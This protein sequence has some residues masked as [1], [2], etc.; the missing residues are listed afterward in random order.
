MTKRLI[1]AL[2]A[3]IMAAGAFA[4]TGC[5]GAGSG[6]TNTTAAATSAASA[7]ATTTTAAT[8]TSAA[9][10][11]DIVDIT[12]YILYEF[13]GPG[14]GCE[15]MDDPVGNLIS[16][17]TGVKLIF[18]SPIGDYQEALALMIASDDY[19]DLI[20]HQ[21]DSFDQLVAAGALAPMK[22]K[23]NS[24]PNIKQYWGED[25][26]KLSYSKE[27][28][29]YYAFG[30]GQRYNSHVANMYAEFGFYLQLDALKSAGFPKITTPEEYEEVLVK[31][32][33]A[34][35]TINGMPSIGLS[36][37]MADGWR[38]KFSVINGASC[39]AGF[40]S[41][42]EWYIDMEKDE[43]SALVR[44]PEAKDF[45]KWLNHMNDIGMLDSEV[46]TQTHDDLDAKIAN[47]RVIGFTDA[48]W[49][50]GKAIDELA[51]EDPE[52]QY[53]GFPARFDPANTEWRDLR[54]FGKYVG[55]GYS[56][57]KSC[58]NIDKIVD[59]WDYLASEE[60]IMLKVWG[61]E[62]EH[63]TIE[64]GKRVET[65][66]IKEMITNSDRAAEIRNNTGVGKY[67]N[68][69]FYYTGDAWVLSNGNPVKDPDPQ[70]SIEHYNSKTGI[71]KETLDA[72]KIQGFNE[73]FPLGYP[74]YFG[75]EIVRQGPLYSIPS[76]LTDETKVIKTQY[77]ES[78]Y[79]IL[80][81]TILANP[82]DFDA[83]WQKYMQELDNMNLNLLEEEYTKGLKDRMELWYGN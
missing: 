56:V 60:G 22:D 3:V 29:E 6:S 42:G 50:H 73:M 61:I 20:G 9:K 34:N 24:R 45:I 71:V 43:V 35:P 21:G 32:K 77:E 25:I 65:A 44:R 74:N 51:I 8:T 52:R 46:F 14:F 78:I 66:I 23:M 37:S 2:L 26:N 15:N 36:F 30:V 63:F 19:P 17:K 33:E 27:D 1:A 72:Y 82:A 31:Y 57:T 47:G 59:F 4:V 10:T 54:N 12:E 69:S 48:W 5:G 38:W 80:P 11:D 75:Q 79:K 58:K 49:Q 28:P 16:Q 62:G 55:T 39:T 76:G 7:A 83:E 70:K 40:P 67:G 64:N 81:K 41:Q 68:P 13:G 18:Q 53:I